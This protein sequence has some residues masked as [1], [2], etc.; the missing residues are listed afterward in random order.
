MGGTQGVANDPPTR[1]TPPPGRLPSL[2]VR[3]Y[4]RAL[5]L[6]VVLP[7]LAFSAFLVLR[8]A[9]HQQELMAN[10]VRQRTQAAAAA[11]DYE[12]SV[13]R[14]RAFRLAG[15]GTLRQRDFALFHR[16]A[17]EVVNEGGLQVILSDPSGQELVDTRTAYGAVLRMIADPDAIRHTA[18][19]GRPNVSD[20]AVNPATKQ[21]FVGI[22]VPIFSDDKVAFVLSLNIAQYL[23]RL[24]AQLDLPRGWV[25]AIV[26]RQGRVIARNRDAERFVG[27]MARPPVLDRFRASND[28][29]FASTS[30]DGVPIYNAYTHMKLVGWVVGTG[31]PDAI[32]FAPV[33]HSTLV[34]FLLG[35]A[36]VALALIAASVI[37]SRIARPI[38]AL[39][40]YAGA[41]G[42]GEP[43][44]LHTTGVR[45]IDA[46]ARS[47][48]EAG[49]Q[50]SQSGQER[51]ELLHRTVELQEQERKRIA[52]ELHD[53]IGQYLAALRLGLDAV[54]PACAADP[55][56]RQRLAEL[57][58][59]IAE[60]GRAFSRMAWELRP[61]ALDELGLTNAITQYLEEWAER[62]GLS[63][64][65][66]IALAG[67]K[68]PAA[69]ETALFRVLQEAITNVVK[70]SGADHVGVVL[71][72]IDGEIRLIVE[73]NGRGFQGDGNTE[74]ALDRTHL[75]L[76]GVRE[77]LSLVN[78]RLE[79][80]SSPQGG[81]TVYA[82][83]LIGEEKEA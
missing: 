42:R 81:T 68:L 36:V 21:P 47:L 12:L 63:I 5:T 70:H 20:Y 77:R 75:G 6:A 52:R 39:A 13:L 82:R 49:E 29:W 2:S 23:P 54:A 56:P 16:Q 10:E 32:L 58:D 27:Q 65:A 9:G 17:S 34:L 35:G 25:S 51:T 1:A 7:L 46:V 67:R 19:T 57:K 66:E 37:G 33:R 48:H 38:G 78:G 45:E 50:L 15:S 71:K 3:T 40:A 28:G 30:L 55:C 44:A 60:M 83:V 22:N 69:V 18:A 79:V 26:D 62:F 43:L 11:L 74:V 53:T 31:I 61:M 64:D 14:A 72:P 73:D 80:E 41:V 24:M 76:L 59:L 8:A 4:M